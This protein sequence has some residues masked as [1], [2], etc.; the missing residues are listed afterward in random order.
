VTAEPEE[1]PVLKRDDLPDERDELAGVRVRLPRLKDDSEQSCPAT[2]Q[3]ILEHLDVEAPGGA[4]SG[5]EEVVE[6]KLKF[7]RTAAIEGTS[8]WI[9]GFKD[10]EGAKS[11]VLV[12]HW[13]KADGD[14]PAWAEGSR[15]REETLLSYEEAYGLKP[16]QFIAA[17]HFGI[18]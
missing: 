10:G 12:G 18:D 15:R 4:Q 9:W 14:A 2:Q 3:D 5:S 16:E 13:R 17:E 6:F 11:Y 7:L 8:Y 1:P